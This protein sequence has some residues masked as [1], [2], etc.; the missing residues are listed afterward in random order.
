MGDPGD[1]SERRYI[2]EWKIREIGVWGGENENY[3]EIR[4]I[5]EWRGNI[6]GWGRWET[7]DWG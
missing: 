4:Y 7:E 2:G 5:E 6:W 1:V 3:W